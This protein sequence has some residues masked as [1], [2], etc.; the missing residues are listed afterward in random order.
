MSKYDNFARLRRYLRTLVRAP[1]V[2]FAIKKDHFTVAFMS[3]VDMG[4]EI[5]LL[6]PTSAMEMFLN[7]RK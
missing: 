3:V 6:T 1:S 7:S 2:C 4:N 5:S